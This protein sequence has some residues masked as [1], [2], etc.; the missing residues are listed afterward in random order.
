MKIRAVYLDSSGAVDEINDALR[1]F[2][3]EN[4]TILTSRWASFHLI[5][6]SFDPD[7]TI[8]RYRGVTVKLFDDSYPFHRAF[9]EIRG[10]NIA[11]LA[12]V[13]LSEPW[14]I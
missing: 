4:V 13:I 3:Y 7:P 5:C 1:D 6:G 12:L 11:D 9:P 2:G 14:D 8:L 10:F